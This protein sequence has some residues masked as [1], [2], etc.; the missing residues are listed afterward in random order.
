[1]CKASGCAFWGL[2]AHSQGQAFA[3]AFKEIILYLGET[4]QNLL[5][6]FDKYY[7]NSKRGA[8]TGEVD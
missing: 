4:Q 3:F 1:M 7:L 5:I 6:N 2:T 8:D